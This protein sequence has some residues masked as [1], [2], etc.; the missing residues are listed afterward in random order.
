MTLPEVLTTTIDLTLPTEK[1]VIKK[2]Q[3]QITTFALVGH[4]TFRLTQLT[5]VNFFRSFFCYA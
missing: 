2:C 1:K 3:Q 4:M 5:F